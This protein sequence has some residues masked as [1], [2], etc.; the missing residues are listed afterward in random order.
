MLD[1]RSLLLP[2][3]QDAFFRQAARYVLQSWKLLADGWSVVSVWWLRF[4]VQERA[5]LDK[6]PIWR[7]LFRWTFLVSN[8]TCKYLLY[9]YQV[10]W[11]L[12]ERLTPE[13]ECY[14]ISITMLHHCIPVFNPH[15]S[16]YYNQRSFSSTLKLT[17]TRF[18]LFMSLI[19]TFWIHFQFGSFFANHHSTT[20]FFI[21]SF[22]FV[23]F[24]RPPFDNHLLTILLP[25]D[26][27]LHC[28]LIRLFFPRIDRSIGVRSPSTFLFCSTFNNDLQT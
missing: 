10:L 2:R 13:I 23:C 7:N 11:I 4:V 9:Q 14:I 6:I 1:W 24:C 16:Q 17:S 19:L 20:R 25:F 12:T 26:H 18:V 28:I 21:V 8:I 15:S 3:V 27:E 22:Y 5:M